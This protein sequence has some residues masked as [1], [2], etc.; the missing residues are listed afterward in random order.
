MSP[1]LALALQ[2]SAALSCPRSG[3]DPGPSGQ[4]PVAMLD[5]S[6]DRGVGIL[7]AV[8]ELDGIG[9]L[10]ALRAF[11]WLLWRLRCVAFFKAELAAA[12]AAARRDRQGHWRTQ[13]H[14]FPIA[15]AKLVQVPDR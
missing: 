3:T 4:R 6:P 14:D 12:V 8:A 15:V 1:S 7:L 2:P 11:L 13:P 5:L 10:V 9:A